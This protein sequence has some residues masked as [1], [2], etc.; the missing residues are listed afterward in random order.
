MP[1][2]V[3]LL[4]FLF[5]TFNSIPCQAQTPTAEVVV[6]TVTEYLTAT[7]P[8]AALSAQYTDNLD[9]RTSVLNSTNL[10]RYEHSAPFLY[11]NSTLASY[12]QSY[13]ETCLW[14]HSKGPYGENLAKGYT[15]VTEAIDAWGDERTD[16]NFSSSDPTG[17]TEATGHFTQLVWNSTQSTGCGWTNC[18]GKNGLEGVF[19]VCEYWPVGNI[20]G[21]NN[22]YFIHNVAAQINQGNGFNEQAATQ[23]ATGGTPSSTASSLSPT[24]SAS[25]S[26]D[27]RSV[28][29]GHR[30]MWTAIGVTIFALLIGIGM[31]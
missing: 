7:A 1:P 26:S 30:R 25:A 24:A 14:E 13:S 23:G 6:T 3:K 21:D 10:F 17:F 11:W 12:A 28:E 9:F 27:G 18:K 2:Y 8:I 15:N 4:F 20:V 22:Y 31:S 16:Y 29:A 5:T 19:L